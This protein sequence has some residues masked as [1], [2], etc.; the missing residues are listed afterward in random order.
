[1]N[2]RL[3]TI[4][5][6]ALAF[7]GGT[8]LASNFRIGL[9]D[10]VDSLDPARSSAYVSNLIYM[11]MCEKLIGLSPDLKF[12]PKLATKWSWSE[13]HKQLTMALRNDVIF[14]DGT[15]FNA[16]AVVANIERGMTMPESRR[17]ID[18]ASVETVKATGDYEVVFKLKE[19]DVTL[20]SQFTGEAGIMVSPTAVEKQGDAF[21][22]NPVCSGPYAFSS[23][24][25]QDRIVLKKF[26]KY[27]NAERYHFDTLTF[28][29][30]PDT[31]VRLANLRSG[32]LDMI[33]RV[34]PTDVASLRTDEKLSIKSI[35]GIGYQA[36]TVNL[37][38]NQAGN[39]PM[40]RQA[41]VRQAFSLSIDRK[42]LNDVVFAGTAVPGNQFV[43]PGS[44]WYASHFPVPVHDI[45]KARAL[46]KEAGVDRVSVEVQVANNPVQLQMM[47]VVQSMVADAGFD[48]KIQSLELASML[49]AQNTGD[50]QIGQIGWTGR[51]D[52]DG[53]IRA[54]ITCKGGPLNDADYCNEKV[55]TLLTLARQS[56][57]DEKRKAIYAEVVSILDNDL[58]IIYLYHPSWIWA[59]N[60]KVEGFVPTPTGLFDLENVTLS[61]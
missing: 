9:Q 28:L 1:M 3:L 59:L 27:R 7:F 61:K 22:N 60:A 29:P 51:V 50:F 17:K 5:V 39:N 20:L 37:R 43:P 19:A 8:A 45:P 14:Q 31:A 4:A 41:K 24:V 35:G 18:L 40:G 6:S 15:P 32:Q 23:R 2:I 30:I 56:V 42:A 48:L 44:P 58:P 34:A 54:Q 11:S 25:A 49:A 46:L 13:D 53:N 57:D 26:D 38:D 16:K 21:G 12:V 47:Q 33:E 55:D 10:D 36:L 52:P